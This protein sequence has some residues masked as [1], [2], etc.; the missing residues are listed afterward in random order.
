MK[1]N[2]QVAMWR[3]RQA[4]S[5]YRGFHTTADSAGAASM[6]RLFQRITAVGDQAIVPLVAITPAMLAV[7]NNQQDHPVGHR[8]LTIRAAVGEGIQRFIHSHATLTLEASLDAIEQLA[9]GY[10]SVANHEGDF[11]IGPDEHNL[12]FWW[13]P[14]RG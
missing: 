9:L 13:W 14:E 2:G 4:R 7:P 3:Y 8:H 6:I 12:W 11:T 10:R 5:G 1:I